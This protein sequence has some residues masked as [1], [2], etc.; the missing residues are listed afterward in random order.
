MDKKI[1]P[2]KLKGFWELMPD[3]QIL[4]SS[5]LSKL[6]KVFKKYTILNNYTQKRNY[7][8]SRYCIWCNY[9]GKW[10]IKTI[11]YEIKIMHNA[12]IGDVKNVHIEHT[13]YKK[14]VI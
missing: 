5:L 11:I 7:G 9:G 8:S 14:E 12:H 6:E 2:R 1:E 4:F 3:E 13:I 10:N